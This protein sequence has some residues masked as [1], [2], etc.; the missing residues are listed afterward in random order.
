[1]DSGQRAN[2][3]GDVTSAI[4]N[5]TVKYAVQRHIM[6]GRLRRPVPMYI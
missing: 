4:I 6:P 2:R 1:M 3:T 5:S